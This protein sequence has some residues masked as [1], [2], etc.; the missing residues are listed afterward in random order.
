MPDETKELELVLR[1]LLIATLH[2]LEVDAQVSI[3]TK[4]GWGNTEIGQITGLAA[5]AVGMRKLRLKKGK[6]K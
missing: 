3:L 6:V 2:P 4:A 5:S 1:A